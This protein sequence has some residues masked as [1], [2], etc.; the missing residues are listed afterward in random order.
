MKLPRLLKKGDG[1]AV[2]AECLMDASKEVLM[3][4]CCEIWVSGGVV[5]LGKREK[6]QLCL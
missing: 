3:R 2:R 1:T 6:R 5:S 4:A